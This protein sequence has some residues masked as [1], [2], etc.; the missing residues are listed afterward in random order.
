MSFLFVARKVEGRFETSCAP[1][2]GM[3]INV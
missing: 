3:F 2:L 1:R